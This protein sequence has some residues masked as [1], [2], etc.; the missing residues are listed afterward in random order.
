KIFEF[1]PPEYSSIY[2]GVMNTLLGYN[3]NSEYVL[4]IKINEFQN[5]ESKTPEYET[6][7][8]FERRSWHYYLPYG[9]WLLD[10]EKAFNILDKLNNQ[11]ITVKENIII[12]SQNNDEFIILLSN[13]TIL[14]NKDPKPDITFI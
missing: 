5:L 11:N 13:A 6:K 3:V 12:K 9:N 14:L 8:S 4:I 2:S 1:S 7:Y 10:F